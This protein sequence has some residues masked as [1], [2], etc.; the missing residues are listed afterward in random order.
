[1]LDEETLIFIAG[2][3]IQLLSIKTKQQTYLRSTSG[4]GIGAIAVSA[5]GL[6]DELE[7]LPGRE[8]RKEMF[9]L[10]THSTH[11]IYGYITW[12]GGGGA[13]VYIVINQIQ[14]EGNVLF[15]NTAFYLWLY[16]AGH[17]VKNRSDSKRVNQLATLSD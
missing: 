1:M 15:N 2:N 11:F 17:M 4:G 14:K 16:G 12:K 8:G 6:L 10:M 7:I 3:F 9:Y 5:Q 13:Y